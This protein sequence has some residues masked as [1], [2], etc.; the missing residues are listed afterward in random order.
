MGPQGCRL[1]ALELVDRPPHDHRRGE[2]QAPEREPERERHGLPPVEAPEEM[3][4]GGQRRFRELHH[5]SSDGPRGA[6][7]RVSIR[8]SD[9]EEKH[10]RSKETVCRQGSDWPRWREVD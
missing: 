2:G 9:L 8:E 4:E 3:S 7:R 1:G 6:R 10:F 5:V